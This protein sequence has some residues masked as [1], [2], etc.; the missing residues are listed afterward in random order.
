M[1]SEM[2]R[3]FDR[4]R[5]NRKLLDYVLCSLLLNKEV[6][7]FG[8]I[9]STFNLYKGELLPKPYAEAVAVL[10]SRDT[11]ARGIGLYDHN[12]DRHYLDFENKA[13]R[14]MDTSEYFDTY[15]N[16]LYFRPL[17]TNSDYSGKN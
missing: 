11:S 13:K 14:K 10:A 5:D 16:Y 1:A 9:L 8:I 6:E 4:N 3:L 2:F 15:W 7:K 12:L 17:G